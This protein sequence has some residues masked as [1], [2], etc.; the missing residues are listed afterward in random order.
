[1]DI[2]VSIFRCLPLG[3]HEACAYNEYNAL[4]SICKKVG[5]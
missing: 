3:I 5:V 1:M 2:K 4:L